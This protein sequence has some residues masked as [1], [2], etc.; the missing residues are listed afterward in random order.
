[1]VPDVQARELHLYVEH[2]NPRYRDSCLKCGRRRD[3]HP[4]MP[5]YD[6][7]PLVRRDPR[8]G[9]LNAV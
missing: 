6:P 2:T 8:T 9:H 4:T 1:M 7:V 3:V 5:P